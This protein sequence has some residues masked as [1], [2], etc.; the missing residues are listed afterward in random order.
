MKKIL[1]LLLVSCL[2]AVSYAQN[3]TGAWARNLDSAEQTLTIV[4]NYFVVTTYKMAE[5]KFIQTRGGT[6]NFDGKQI[7]GII[8]FNS[9]DKAEVKSSYTYTC[10]IKG[11]RLNLPVDGI[12]TEWTRIDNAIEGLSG[13]WR[14][15][16]R[17]QGDKMSAINPGVRKTIKTMSGTRFQWT[18]INTDTGEFFG[19]GGGTY[20][21]KDGKYTENIQFFSRDASRVGASLTFDAEIRQGDWHHSGKSSKGEPIY[22]V[23][24]R[25]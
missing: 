16:G 6:A 2:S 12:K 19:T 20:T 7:R 9:L 13:N 22:E 11:K 1:V 4:D 17:M 18:A 25:K 5:K 3:P 23:W 15:T 21:F 8:E 14:I 24:S 10:V